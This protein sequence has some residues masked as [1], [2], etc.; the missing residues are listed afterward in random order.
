MRH[1]K[2]GS[3]NTSL[4][5]VIAASC[6]LGSAV[7]PDRS[8]ATRLAARHVGRVLAEY[9]NTRLAAALALLASEFGPSQE[10]LAS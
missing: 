5:E 7:S 2:R 10:S 8:V 4:G 1:T 9:G 6:E 3:G